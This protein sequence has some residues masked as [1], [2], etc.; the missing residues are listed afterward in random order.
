[1]CSGRKQA[2]PPLS[3]HEQL[4]IW[5]NYC[6]SWVRSCWYI[7]DSQAI[8][9]PLWKRGRKNRT[10]QQEF[11]VNYSK[12]RYKDH[13]GPKDVV[14]VVE[15]SGDPGSPARFRL[16][17]FLTG[18][19]YWIPE[20][21]S[22]QGE[23]FVYK[24]LFQTVREHLEERDLQHLS[25]SF[26]L[27]LQL[28]RRLRFVYSCWLLASS[29]VSWFTNLGNS[30]AIPVRQK[31]VAGPQGFSQRAFRIN[32]F[33]SCFDF[34]LRFQL[35]ANSFQEKW[36]SVTNISIS[37]PMI[38]IGT[39]PHFSTSKLPNIY[40]RQG[41]QIYC[42]CDISWSLIFLTSALEDFTISFAAPMFRWL[43]VEKCADLSWCKAPCG[44]RIRRAEPC[45]SGDCCLTWV[46]LSRRGIE[47]H[48]RAHVYVC[49]KGSSLHVVSS[50]Q[51]QRWETCYRT[52]N[53]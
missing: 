35:R 18:T 19:L 9:D 47:R 25:T 28:F 32:S 45:C 2:S 8:W 31:A 1:M 53:C 39:C 15:A 46:G 14:S 21:A 11:T 30:L 52:V 26:Q 43:G 50:G 38:W 49:L 24:E 4:S 16:L 44:S 13:Q 22:W 20:I 29:E 5:C 12:P 36:E 51:Q 3:T 23:T 42:F 34:S 7:R 27:C 6:A 10:S 40:H 48:K 33:N 17:R 37:F 41:P